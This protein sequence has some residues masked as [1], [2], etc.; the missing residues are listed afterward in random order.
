MKLNIYTISHPIVQQLSSAV[1]QKNLISNVRHQWLRQLGLLL[2]YETIRSWLNIYQ[3]TIKKI[4]YIE[5]T[6]IMDPKE[7]YIII[8]NTDVDLSLIQE[9][10]YLLPQCHINLANSKDYIK[11]MQQ[12][13][14]IKYLNKNVKIIIISAELDADY[15]LETVHK[16]VQTQNI[17]IKQIRIA[18]IKCETE[19]LV[20]INQ[21]YPMLNIFTANMK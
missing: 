6:V 14:Q 17:S 12:Y 15:I 4:N 2:I 9:A 8:A 16:L 18:C 1:K 10:Q 13:S 5:D 3:V 7:S 19:K 21:N 20:N 11:N